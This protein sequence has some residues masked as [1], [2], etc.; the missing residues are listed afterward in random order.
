MTPP[1]PPSRFPRASAT[2]AVALACAALVLLALP[3]DVEHQVR[4][5]RGGIQRLDADTVHE[6]GTEG[7]PSQL[8]IADRGTPV[9]A[10]AARDGGAGTPSAMLAV[11]A[12]R[13]GPPGNEPTAPL[14]PSS[15]PSPFDRPLSPSAGR[16]PPLS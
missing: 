14:R 11:A 3:R 9:T 7:Q 13:L 4:T 1:N 2:L 5:T 15:I 8:S 10:V 12:W 6:H 16:A